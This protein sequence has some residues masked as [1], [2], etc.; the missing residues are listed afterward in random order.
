MKLNTRYE[1]LFT[2]IRVGN[3]IL[4]NRII[5]APITSYAIEP[6]PAD[7]VESIA[8]KAR[9]GAGLVI[10]GSIG[11]NDTD[12]LIYF[13]SSSLW[14]PEKKIFEEEI[15]MIHQYG[16]KASAELFHAGQ[17]ADCRR[18]H[19]TP[20]GPCTME[21]SFSE[22]N[23]YERIE[24]DV[25]DETHVRGMDK[26]DIERV[27]AEF[28]ASA[29]EARRMGFD[30]VMLH[31]G[32]GWLPA[33]FMSPFFNHRT[34]EYGGSFENRIRFPKEIIQAVRKAVGPAYPIDIRIGAEE[35]VEGGLT[36]EEVAQFIYEVQDLINMAH[37]SSG[38]D[39]LVHATSYIEAPS[40]HPHQLNVPFAQIVKQ[41]VPKIPVA[42]VGSITTPDEAEQILQEGSADL[43]ALGR[44]FVA[45]PDWAVKARDNRPEEI[46]TCIRC[47][48]CYGVATGGCSQGCAVNPRY[49]RELR[50]QTE[51]AIL[52][53]KHKADKVA[54][55]KKIAVIG[56][57]PAGMSAAIA[58]A[59]RGHEVVLFEKTD[60]LGGLLNI[61]E[62]DPHKLDMRNFRNYLITM[63]RKLPI[64]VR[65]NCEATPEM[66]R[67]LDPDE[68]ICALGSYPRGLKLE[69]A[70]LPHVK[71]IVEAHSIPLG[72]HVVIIGGG[73]SGCELALSLADEGKEVTILEMMDRL[74]AA[75]NLL[76]RGA[77]SE[78]LKK[79]PQIH[80][81]LGV[82][83]QKITEDAVYY[84]DRD[85]KECIAKADNVVLCVGLTPRF[86]EAAAFSELMY[87]VR[88]V[89]D[90][91]APR[92]INEA[93]HEGYFAGYYI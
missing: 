23:G 83:T 85:G 25:V 45:D 42:V 11:V 59:E 6:S 20:I 64:E 93:V 12:S 58:A 36:P 41:K 33:Q 66:I 54:A 80:V 2:P 16:A 4:K 43:V 13:E 60:K 22:V 50:L 73:P 88:I 32:H 7:K 53:R 86:E 14:G 71:N 78:Q 37:I 56:G 92:R 46:R 81:G 75:G 69:G 47:V 8:A 84:L 10:I 55:G 52:R 77:L 15:S 27:C 35:Y 1:K 76:Y 61:S 9:G 91:A 24:P 68:I 48:S 17:F 51:E 57:G 29:V 40:L 31:L 74:A 90:C 65:L 28:A 34:D 19:A 79:R 89:G 62:T 72:D 18:T 38:L 3:T 70:D 63:T 67:E 21:R 5:A 82:R 26:A 49:E 44:P 87:D 30:M 39:K